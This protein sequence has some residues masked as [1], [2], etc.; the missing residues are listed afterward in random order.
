M[1]GSPSL[2]PHRPLRRRL[3]AWTGALAA[4]SGLMTLAGPAAAT[5]PSVSI[6][7]L[8]FTD[9]VQPRLQGPAFYLKGDGAPEARSFEAFVDQLSHEPVDVVVMGASYRDWEGECRTLNALPNVNSC[10][11]IVIRDARD[12]ADPDVLAALKQAEVVYFRGGD[13][14]NFV[15]WRNSPIPAAVQAVVERGG[16]TGGGSAGLAIQGS[17]AVYDGCRGSV[18]SSLAL[19]D[20][21]RNSVS[22]TENL[23]NWPGL[24]STLTD[25]H[26]VKR[27]RMGRLLAFL[28]RQLGSR[29]VDEAWGLGINEGTAVLIDRDGKGT[30]YGDTAFVVLADRPGYGCR[31]ENDPVTYTGYKVWRLEP[32]SLYDFSERP[33]TGFYRLDVDQGVVLSRNPYI[34][35]AL[36][37]A[38]ATAGRT[39][40]RFGGL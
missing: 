27:D 38:H 8:G 13:Q 12:A 40:D 18:N 14:C 34:A 6:S 17:L 11:T 15:Q 26:F 36:S 4:A 35:P 31:Q 9:D 2:P 28:C 30:V 16:G 39:P 32:G 1:P 3:A 21:Y 24:E 33:Q 7:R 37:E 10:T 29:E 23:F 19:A 20:P 25:S 22:F 5:A